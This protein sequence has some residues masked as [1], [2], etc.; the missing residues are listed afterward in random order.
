MKRHME[1][2]GRGSFKITDT[3]VTPRRHL[4]PLLCYLIANIAISGCLSLGYYAR[5][6]WLKQQAFQPHSFPKGTNPTRG[7]HP[8][9]LITPHT[10]AAG[11]GFQQWNLG[12]DSLSVVE[13]MHGK[14]EI[15]GDKA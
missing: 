6:P 13:I 8:C 4:P 3:D 2:V 14:R 15:L 10:I 7:L 5:K 11:A 9:A 12:K 1:L